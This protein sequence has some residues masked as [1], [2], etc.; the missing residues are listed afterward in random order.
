MRITEEGPDRQCLVAVEFAAVVEGDG[1]SGFWWHA[2]EEVG[3]GLRRML[4]G[5]VFQGRG[6]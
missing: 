6:Q 4:S 1:L 5:L 2:Q 3:Q